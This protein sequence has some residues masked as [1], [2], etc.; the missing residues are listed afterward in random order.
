VASTLAGTAR[1]QPP[2]DA[3]LYREY[4]SCDLLHEEEFEMKRFI[5][6]AV[7]AMLAA[8]SLNAQAPAGW[9]MRVDRSMNASDPDASGSIKFVTQGSGFHANNPQAAVYWNPSNTATGNYTLKGTF[10]LVKTMGHSEYYGLIFGGNGLDAAGQN[11]IYFM[12]EEGGTWLVKSRTGNSTGE[13]ASS[14]G[15]SNVVKK[16]GPNGTSTNALEVRV[17]ADKIDFVVNGTVVKSVPKSGAAAKTD[18]TY[19]MRINHM[20]EVQVDGFGLSK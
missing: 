6:V 16:V 19:G 10:T 12:V 14:G 2:L 9:K 1:D 11:Y 18:G 8:M 13:I 20:L 15:P 7:L 4:Y 17:G 5:S 3:G